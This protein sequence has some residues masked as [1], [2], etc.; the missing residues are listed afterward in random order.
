[1]KTQGRKWRYSL[2][3]RDCWLVKLYKKEGCTT[4]G[5]RKRMKK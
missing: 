3:G 2:L 1:M 5:Y 4:Y